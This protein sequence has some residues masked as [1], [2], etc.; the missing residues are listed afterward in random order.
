M[1][2]YKIPQDIG[3]ED[4]IVG[5]FSLRQLL[6]VAVGGGISYAIFAISSRLYLTGYTGVPPRKEIAKTPLRINALCSRTCGIFPGF[7]QHRSSSAPASV[8]RPRSA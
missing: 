1:L 2:Q 7:L 4:K 3:I 5:P 6:I 8:P